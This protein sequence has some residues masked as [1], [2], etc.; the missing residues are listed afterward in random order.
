MLTMRY[1]NLKGVLFNLV[2]STIQYPLSFREGIFACLMAI[3]FRLYDMGQEYE[4][5]RGVLE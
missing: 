1:D 3:L 4:K 5:S 2:S